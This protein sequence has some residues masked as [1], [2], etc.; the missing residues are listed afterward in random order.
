[1]K[2]FFL[3]IASK[4]ALALTQPP[5]QW[6]PR[7]L[8]LGMK[9]P[10]SKDDHSLPFNAEVKVKVKVKVKSLYFFLLTEHHTMKAYW[11]VEVYL[12]AFVTSALHGGEWSASRPDRF[13]P[14]ERS[15]V[16]TA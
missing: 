10:E 14:M 3:V 9:W 15:P 4:L 8:S 12:H 13:T 16:S 11:E 7:A 2:E 5:I 6:V 1:M